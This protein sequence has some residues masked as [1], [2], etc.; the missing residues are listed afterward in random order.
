MSQN[1]DKQNKSVAL[2]IANNELVFQ[3]GEK[4]KC[5]EELIIANKQLVFQNTE[6]GKRAA[7]L[8]IADK[9]LVFQKEEKEKRAAELIIANKEKQYHALIE[10]GNDAIVIFN[11]EGKPTYVS[12]SIKR[13]LGYSEEE[14]MQLGIYKLVH[15]DD[16]E[17]LSNKM[18][19]CLGK[20]GICLE[21]HVCRIKHKSES[22]NWV[23]ATITNMLQDSDI[24]GIVANFRDAVYNGEVYILSSVGNGC[25]MKVI[26]KGAQSEKI[27]TDNN[28]KFLNN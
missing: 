16:R 4:E 3:N 21:G 15:L 17:A 2:K 26:F 25:K 9:E 27:I 14:A 24:N 13:V 7:E 12:R 19:E 11:L 28:I 22:W 6:K 5:A 20:P 10:N 8:I 1:M 23:E 18:A